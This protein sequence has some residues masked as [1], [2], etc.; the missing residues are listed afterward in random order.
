MNVVPLARLARELHLDPAAAAPVMRV[1]LDRAGLLVD[2]GV[3]GATLAVVRPF[4]DDALA[5]TCG[6]AECDVMAPRLRGGSVV[7][8]GAHRCCVCGGSANE[9]ARARIHAACLA[10]GARRIVVVGGTPSHR[11]EILGGD[12]RWQR[13]ETSPGGIEWRFV[14]GTAR[15]TEAAARADIA[16]ADV[17]VIWAPTRLAHTVSDQYTGSARHGRTAVC[18][19]KGLG[20]LADSIA[21]ALAG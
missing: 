4:L 9:R 17:V 10:S 12:A 3:D 19:R 14:D 11:D 20:G 18:T 1:V 6:Q 7:H 13:D 2:D 21:A 8:V 5:L 15:R 16:W